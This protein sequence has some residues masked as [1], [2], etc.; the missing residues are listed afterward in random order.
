LRELGLSF[1]AI[2]GLLTGLAGISI[3]LILLMPDVD[4]GF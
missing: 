3:A 1:D 2:A 4:A